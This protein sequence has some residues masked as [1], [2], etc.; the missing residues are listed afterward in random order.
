MTVSPGRAYANCYSQAAG[1]YVRA[2][3][4]CYHVTP[5]GTRDHYTRYGSWVAQNN[6]SQSIAYC[7]IGDAAEGWDVQLK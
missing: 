4:L 7:A 2:K 3:A 1:T 6:K 5:T